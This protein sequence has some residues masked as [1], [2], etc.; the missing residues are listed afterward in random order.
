M[1][2]SHLAQARQSPIE[3]DTNP[4][5]DLILPLID[6]GTGSSIPDIPLKIAYS[7]LEISL[8]ESK[9][10]FLFRFLK[11]FQTVRSFVIG[12]RSLSARF[13][14]G[15]ES[16]ILQGNQAAAFLARSLLGISGGE[17]WNTWTGSKTS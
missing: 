2:L 17:K 4:L 9:Q 11:I 16:A 1:V 14:P 3:P 5:F 12:L 10:N 13:G 15:L 6:L 7:S 8:S